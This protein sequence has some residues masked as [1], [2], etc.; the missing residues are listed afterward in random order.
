MIKLFIIT[1]LLAPIYTP[2][3][4]AI[5]NVRTYTVTAYTSRVEETDLD[6]FTMAN[7][8][9]VHDGA[10]A[11][12]FLPFGTKLKIEGF[13]KIFTVEDRMAKRFSD[14]ID[15]WFSDLKKAQEFG[16]KMLEVEILN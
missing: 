10:V 2:Y 14:R 12:N 7:G 4:F 16:K 5:D 9:S 3:T 15:I 6:P 1:L 13:D 11:T 8:E